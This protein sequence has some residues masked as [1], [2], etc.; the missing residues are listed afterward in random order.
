MDFNNS[1]RTLWSPR[2]GSFQQFDAAQRQ[3]NGATIGGNVL[4]FEAGIE[5]RDAERLP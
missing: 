4:R 2:S 3:R 5:E 1:L